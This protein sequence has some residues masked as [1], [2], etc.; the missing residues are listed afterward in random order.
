MRL[1]VCGRFARLCTRIDFSDHVTLY[2]NPL[3]RFTNRIVRN[4]FDS[5]FEKYVIGLVDPRRV[6]WTSVLVLC[7][8][9]HDLDFF[10]STC[11]LTVFSFTAEDIVKKVERF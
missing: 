1:A 4:Q 10:S 7:I 8:G 6:S 2:R 3:N 9:I 11:L 5:I